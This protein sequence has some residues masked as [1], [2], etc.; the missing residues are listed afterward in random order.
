MGF[1][2]RLVGEDAVR[3]YE[4]R[5]RVMAPCDYLAEARAPIAVSVCA[6]LTSPVVRPLIAMGVA[7]MVRV[8]F[9]VVEVLI[10]HFRATPSE[11]SPMGEALVYIYMALDAEP[12]VAGLL[13]LVLVL[14]P[15]LLVMYT[16][17]YV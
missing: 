1:L 6:L 11:P 15:T 14:Q 17:T 16:C 8:C 2:G 9:T 3:R 7:L 12:H 13:S 5:R 4:E 10:E